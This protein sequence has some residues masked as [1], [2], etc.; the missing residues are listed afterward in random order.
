MGQKA[1][2]QAI[3]EADSEEINATDDGAT[4]LYVAAGEGH[5]AVVRAL[6]EL[7]RTS[8]RRKTAGRRCT[9]LLKRATGR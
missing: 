6:I 1:I 8:T 4:P 7:G 3:I 2:V 9:C 5:E